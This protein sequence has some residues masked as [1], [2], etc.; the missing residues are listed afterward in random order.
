MMRKLCL[1]SAALAFCCVFPSSSGAQSPAQR[2]QP[3]AIGVRVLG[4]FA[5]KQS[6]NG[7]QFGGE[8]VRQTGVDEPVELAVGGFYG[9]VGRHVSTP[10]CLLPC[11]QASTTGAFV[12]GTGLLL[13]YFQ[14]NTRV[15]PF[16]GGGVTIGNHFD[17]VRYY[18]IAV[19]GGVSIA[20]GDRGK[21]R[22]D[23][24]L[25]ENF[26]LMVGYGF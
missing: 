26:A 9:R 18:N 1:V 19:S 14:P 6:L 11:S 25:A 22:I 10:G 5:N 21:V 17:R 24:R 8:V 23:A 20:T 7:F 13:F 2:P 3:G 15:R 16:A 4:G 12:E